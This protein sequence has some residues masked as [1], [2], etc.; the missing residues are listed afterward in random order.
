MSTEKQTLQLKA[1]Q[2][3][4]MSHRKIV[5]TY[6]TTKDSHKGIKDNWES[7]AENRVKWVKQ[8]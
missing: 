8:H 7:E 2:S 3:H 6:W 4:N 5:I 1:D